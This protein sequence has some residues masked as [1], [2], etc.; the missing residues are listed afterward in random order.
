MLQVQPTQA[1][2]SGFNWLA[3]TLR[4]LKWPSTKVMACV[5]GKKIQAQLQCLF[6]SRVPIM[7]QTIGYKPYHNKILA[8]LLDY[9]CV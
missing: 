1:H 4:C 5:A 7:A 6:R 2:K 3:E 8:S 9:T